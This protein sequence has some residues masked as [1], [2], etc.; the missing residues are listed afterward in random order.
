MA[1]GRHPILDQTLVPLLTGTDKGS[2]SLGNFRGI[3]YIVRRE[4][5]MECITEEP[6]KYLLLRL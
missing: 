6:E 1:E 4:E 5:V 3:L 2:F